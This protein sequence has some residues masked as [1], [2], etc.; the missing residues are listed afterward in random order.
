MVS[1]ALMA[2]LTGAVFTLLNASFT[3]MAESANYIRRTQHVEA[4]IVL[5]RSNLRKLPPT[6]WMTSL[7]N[8]EIE[9]LRTVL[10][11]ESAD[12]LRDDSLRGSPLMICGVA[13]LFSW[14]TAG[15][16]T[17]DSATFTPSSGGGAPVA[18]PRP[19]DP[20]IAVH[21]LCLRAQA[22]GT[23][24]LCAISPDWPR[25]LPLLDNIL[26]LRWRFMAAGDN[27]WKEHWTAGARP[28]LAE[29]TFTTA[30]SPSDPIRNVFWLAVQPTTATG[31]GGRR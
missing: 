20:P 19:G 24:T 29:L 21:I 28:A 27:E 18:T 4:C 17:L 2:I 5:L 12:C 3:G 23:M 25:P 9:Y 16:A 22:D 8:E 11:K 30:E 6:S 10:P 13:E 26:D 15:K 14:Q 31:A 7:G 1:L